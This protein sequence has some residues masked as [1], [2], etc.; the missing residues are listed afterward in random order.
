[1]QYLCIWLVEILHLFS[2]ETKMTMVYSSC[3]AFFN[4]FAAVHKLK[5]G[6]PIKITPILLLIA[7]MI[8]SD[9]GS[10]SII[11]PQCIIDLNH[12]RLWA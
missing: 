7:F 4:P 5:S 8:E 9:T 6:S 11:D 2:N 3:F 1:M 10:E 12:V